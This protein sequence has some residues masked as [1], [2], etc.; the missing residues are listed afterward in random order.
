LRA[1]VTY[2]TPGN[3]IYTTLGVQNHL[4]ITSTLYGYAVLRTGYPAFEPGKGSWTFWKRRPLQD[5]LEAILCSAVERRY[6]VCPETTR[7]SKFRTF[8]TFKTLLE[9]LCRSICH[10]VVGPPYKFVTVI[11]YFDYAGACE[12]Y[13]DVHRF[14]SVV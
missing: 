9:L 1:V 12:W 10:R 14:L 6:T 8:K 2:H 11:A 5:L 13:N 3:K 7:A 4:D